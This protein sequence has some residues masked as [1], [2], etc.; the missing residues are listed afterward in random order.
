MPK[1]NPLPLANRCKPAGL[2]RIIFSAAMPLLASSLLR[3]ALLAAPLLAAPLLATPLLSVPLLSVPLLSAPLLT[4]PLP[5][6][7]LPA[8]KQSSTHAGGQFTHPGAWNSQQNLD[9]VKNKIVN[10]EAPWFTEFERIR[11]SPSASRAPHPLRQIPLEG[12]HD[13]VF[14]DDAIAAYTQALLWYFTGNK[15]YG[16]SAIAILNAWANFEEFTTGSQQGSNQQQLRAGWIGAVLAQAADIM[17][18][19]PGWSEANINKLQLMFK[20]AFYP[21]LTTMSQWNGNVDLTQIEALL[22]IAVFNQDEAVFNLGLVRLNQR[23]PAYFYL[24][25]DGP[26]PQAI[27]GDGN[28]LPAFWFNPQHMPNGL[29]QETCRDNGHHT[30]FGLGSALHAAEIAWNQGIDLYTPHQKRFTSALELLASQ[31]LTQSFV[32]CANVKPTQ[33]LFNTWEIGYNHYH[34][35]QG[36]RLPNTQKLIEQHVRPHSTRA[37]WNLVYE[38]LTHAKKYPPPK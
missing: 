28:N 27:A 17:R 19:Y 23:I 35:R 36:L 38:T 3:P 1:K 9:Y 16:D 20:R 13:T 21:Q 5:T 10:K 33:S 18:G 25:S 26:L 6:S 11:Q 4:A 14:R 2:L 30:Q 22:A 31:I 12:N 32:P 8:I 34:N 37:V 15:T 24:T 29:T 7:P